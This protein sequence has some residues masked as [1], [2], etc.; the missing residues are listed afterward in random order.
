MKI[1]NKIHVF[2]LDNTLISTAQA[3]VSSLVFAARYVTVLKPEIKLSKGFDE[4][5]LSQSA[6]ELNQICRKALGTSSPELWLE[7][8]LKNFKFDL[9]PDQFTSLLDAQQ[10]AFWDNLKVI[11]SAHRFLKQVQQKG[12]RLGIVS[13]GGATIQQKKV[14]HC[15][16]DS[17]FDTEHTMF[18]GSYEFE[19]AKP[20]PHMLQ[21]LSDVFEA[22]PESITYY[23]DR[24]SDI[25]AGNAVGCQT[26]LYAP[27]PVAEQ[28]LNLAKADHIFKS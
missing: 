10:N 11:R 9:S 13:N 15:G 6:V 14:V 12:C 25:V 27:V 23:G 8:W 2:D 24:L 7:L 17:I 20:S 4:Q 18:S 19:Q 5:L 16:L 3:L 21:I 28:N 26:L 1:K 22:K